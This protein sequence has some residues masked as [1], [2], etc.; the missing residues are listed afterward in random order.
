MRTEPIE[1]A[2]KPLGRSVPNYP[3]GDRRDAGVTRDVSDGTEWDENPKLATKLD[4]R[5]LGRVMS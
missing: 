4:I 3:V 5:Y 2:F 1:E